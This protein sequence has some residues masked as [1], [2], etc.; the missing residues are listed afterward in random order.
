LINKWSVLQ[1]LE[2]KDR[3]STHHL[4]NQGIPNKAHTPQKKYFKKS[5][6]LLFYFLNDDDNQ[7]TSTHQM[8]HFLINACI[9]LVSSFTAVFL[10]CLFFAPSPSS[11]QYTSPK[12]KLPVHR[13]S[14]IGLPPNRESEQGFIRAA[15]IGMSAVVHIE[16]IDYYEEDELIRS[17]NSSFTKREVKNIVT[18]S[19]IIVSPDG[20]VVTNN[21]VVKHADL[22]E[23]TLANDQKINAEIIGKDLTSD[24]VLL[25][26]DLA[27]LPFLQ[28]TDSDNVSV[29][30]WVLAVGN[31]F[32]LYSTVTAGIISAKG[33]PLNLTGDEYKTEVYIQTD[34]A[35]NQGSS[36]G[37]L[38][39][40][41]GKLVG[42]ITAIASSSG[43]FEGYS[44]AVP[45]NTIQKVITDIRQ[46]GYVRRAYLGIVMRDVKASDGV[47]KGVFVAGI[48]KKSTLAK[49]GL[50]EGDIIVKINNHNVE[51]VND[52]KNRMNQ[53]D[54]GSLANVAFL[55]KGKKL[56]TQLLLLDDQIGQYQAKVRLE[57][58]LGIEIEN[59][60]DDELSSSLLNFGVKIVQINKGIISNNTTIKKNLIIYK[61]NNQPIQS[62][63]DFEKIINTLKEGDSITILGRYTKSKEDKHFAFGLKQ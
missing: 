51:N 5:N 50:E 59:T 60:S 14:N 42:M 36:G 57:S 29:G 37:A 47:H 6:F 9:A 46:H 28:M 24:I 11:L 1:C 12:V 23:I 16:A 31:P 32:K 4:L 41:E 10:Y 58:L 19:G 43:L 3:P 53:Q 27:N 39:N 44:F 2:Y 30:Q 13:V 61:I 7:F 21:H 38:I 22:L 18:G 45:V 25:K 48:D 52:L 54:I 34:A 55:R 40:R 35:V 15:A 17:A 8:K 56:Y 62:I 49:S 26:I 33:R 20:Y 63:K